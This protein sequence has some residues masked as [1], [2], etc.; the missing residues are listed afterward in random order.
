MRTRRVD[1]REVPSERASA[2]A[3][4]VCLEVED[5]GSGM[6]P[7]VRDKIFEP[8]FTTKKQDRGTG[9]GLAVVY[10]AVENAGGVID[11]QTAEGV[12]T[13]FRG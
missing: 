13:T 10:G 7:A 8:Y 9:L 11:V 6:S 2:A 3:Q 1:V 5:T 4:W 12:G